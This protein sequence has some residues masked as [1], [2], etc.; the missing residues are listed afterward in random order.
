MFTIRNQKT[1]YPIKVK[2]KFILILDKII[3]SP[4]NFIKPKNTK[5]AK[6]ND[7]PKDIHSDKNILLNLIDD[8][9]AA[10]ANTMKYN[11]ADVPKKRPFKESLTILIRNK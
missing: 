5:Y 8:W 3:S 9:K 2:T 6:I 10:T 4:D 11:I 1:G 7:T